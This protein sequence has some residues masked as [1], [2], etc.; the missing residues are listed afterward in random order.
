M[1]NQNI[2]Y[3]TDSIVGVKNIEKESIHAI[4]SDIPYGI[5]YDKWDILHNNKNSSLGKN[6]KSG[7]KSNLFKRRGK[8]LNGWSED[9][10]KYQKNMA[11]GF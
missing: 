1:Q 3:N 11:I 4:I 6:S 5:S 2:F 9:D 7:E 10:K 8:P